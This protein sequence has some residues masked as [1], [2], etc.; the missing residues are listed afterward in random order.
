MINYKL[1]LPSIGFS[2]E[3]DVLMHIFPEDIFSW[4]YPP[5]F[6][7]FSLNLE[8]IVLLQKYKTVLSKN[9]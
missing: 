5:P 2:D 4:I 6:F 3:H 7:H 8:M 1:K 9:R